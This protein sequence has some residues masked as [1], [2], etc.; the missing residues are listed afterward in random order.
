M[1]IKEKILQKVVDTDEEF[2]YIVSHHFI[3]YLPI[4]VLAGIGVII[5][6][7]LY[8]FVSQFFP[9]VATLFCW[10][11]GLLLY[12]YFLL[13]FLDVYLDSIAVSPTSLVIYKWYGL[14]KNTTDVLDLSAV[15]SVFAEQSWL[16]D[17]LFNNWDIYIRR[18]GYTNVFK[19]VLNPNGVASKINSIILSVK[20]GEDNSE[21]EKFNENINDDKIKVLAK[22][23]IEV[24]KEMK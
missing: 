21:K 24:L 4:L 13:N 16:L 10:T 7:F 15:E 11:L 18:A 9:T 20:S 3:V 12:F 22:A 8:S 6:F 2:I 19:N 23:M 1:N 17:V 14:F 5:L